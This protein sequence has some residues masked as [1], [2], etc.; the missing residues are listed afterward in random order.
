NRGRPRLGSVTRAAA[1]NAQIKMVST[2]RHKAGGS[3]TGIADE[4]GCPQEE[5]VA[6]LREVTRPT[7]GPRPE[8][9]ATPAPPCLRIQHGADR[10]S[11][12]GHDDNEKQARQASFTRARWL[13]EAQALPSAAC[14]PPFLLSLL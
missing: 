13:E 12:A 6:L 9:R 1:A 3:L 8:R 10:A 11:C 2:R 4:L 7:A 14:P 5:L